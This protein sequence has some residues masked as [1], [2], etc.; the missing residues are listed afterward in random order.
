MSAKLKVSRGGKILG[1][2]TKEE[3]LEGLSK[4]TFLPTDYFWDPENKSAGWQKLSTLSPGSASSPPPPAP[5]V[6]PTASPAQPKPAVIQPAKIETQ[7]GWFKTIRFILGIIVFFW[8]ALLAM[9]GAGGD[10][11]GSAIRQAVLAQHVTNGL[12]LMILAVLIAR[13]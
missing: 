3:V 7:W 13:K 1:D 11:T 5:P 6:K 2:F 9:I 4:G 8:G 10:P 12:L